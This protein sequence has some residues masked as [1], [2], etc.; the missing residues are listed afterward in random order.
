VDEE[1]E[2]A[3]PDNRAGTFGMSYDD[4][5]DDTY[6]ET[7]DEGAEDGGEREDGQGD[8]AMDADAHGDA[9]DDMWLGMQEGPARGGSPGA[10]DSDLMMF[11]TP[12]ANERVRREAEDIA[13]ASAMQSVARRREHKFAPLAKDLYGQMGYA[14]IAEPPELILRTEAE[15]ARLYDDGVGEAN[16]AQKLDDTLATAAGKLA[17]LWK[18]YADKLPQSDEEH[19]AEIGPGPHASPFEKANYL[20]NLALQI[21]HT[22]LGE[23]E[24]LATEPLPETL[25]RW[26]SDYHNLYP[27]QFDDINKH[28]PSP[29]CHGLF[30]QSVFIALLRGRVVDAQELLRNAGWGHVRRGHRGEYA[31]TGQALENVER[32]VQDTCDM[33]NNCPG[34]EGNWEIRGSD[35]TLFRL[36]ARGALEQLRRFAEGRDSSFGDSTLSDSTRGR[37]SVAGLARKAESRVPW[38]IYENLNIVFEIVLGSQGAILEAAQ[39]WCEA[40]VGLFG[41]WDEGKTSNSENL[42]FSRSQSLLLLPQQTESEGYLDR[43]ARAFQTAVESDFHFNSLN[44]VEVGMACVF[45]DNTKGLIGILRAWSLPIASAVAEIASLGGWLPAHQPSGLYAMGD[46]DMDDLEVLGMDPGSPDEMD[47]IKDNTLIQYAQ[48]LANLKEMSSAKDKS[49]T[50]RDGWEVAI[51][52]LGRMDS[53]ERSEEMVG[54]LVQSLLEHLDVDSGVTVDKVWRLLNEL[55]MIPL[56]EETAEVRRF[57]SELVIDSG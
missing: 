28:R 32:A 45:E 6:D 33:L 30:W 16:D 51:T 47:G 23:D 7:Y 17:S 36:R 5:Y 2:D 3:L 25:F 46:L 1:E 34:V 35:W 4:T 40:T 26:L 37:Q 43:L 48:E 31:Y 42:H 15:V 20:A 57:L 8:D 41:W 19:G 12:A 53:P 55:G 11:A 39:D 50:F 27:G 54:E 18:S 38:D 10:E 24:R 29:A 9:E 52:V 44:P 21:H 49:G 14:A 13:R 22:R 56:A